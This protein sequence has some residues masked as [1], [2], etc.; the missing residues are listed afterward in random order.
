M[1]SYD[2]L[3]LIELG[4]NNPEMAGGETSL[5][6]VTSRV[7]LVQE[8]S[9]KFTEIENNLGE[10]HFTNQ[11]PKLRGST[12][13]TEVT[14]GFWISWTDSDR[15]PILEIGIDGQETPFF[16]HM[17][18]K[19]CFDCDSQ[20]NFGWLGTDVQ[21]PRTNEVFK[22]KLWGLESV[23][24][25]KF[26]VFTNC[27]N[28]I[29]SRHQTQAIFGGTCL[30]SDQCRQCAS[31]ACSARVCEVRG[32]SDLKWTGRKTCTQRLLASLPLEILILFILLGNL[33]NPY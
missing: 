16:L 26:R 4:D 6:W 31:E 10:S 17:F 33:I 14:T 7:S 3:L 5:S 32:I 9:G 13:N 21:L 2:A 8:K 23:Q 12:I 20:D 11:F 29:Y 22:P 19:F 15:G 24:G 1:C 18:H 30:N 28:I 27:S 25:N